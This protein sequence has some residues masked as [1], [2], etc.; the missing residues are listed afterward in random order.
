M[1]ATPLGL[2]KTQAE[3]LSKG[4]ALSVKTITSNDGSVLSDITVQI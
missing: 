3:I 1:G 4:C 2:N